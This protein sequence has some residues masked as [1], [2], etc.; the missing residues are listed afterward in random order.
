VAIDDGIGQIEKALGPRMRNTLFVFAS[1]NDWS[2]GAHRWV[3]K[4]VP[5]NESIRVP[6][7]MRWDAHIDPGTTNPRLAVNVDWAETFAAAAG[8]T[9]GGEGEDLLDGQ[10]GRQRFPVESYS[11]GAELGTRQLPTYCG[12]RSRRWLYVKDEYGELELYNEL[13]DPFEMH[14]LAYNPAYHQVL[15]AMHANAVKLCSPPPP[16]FTP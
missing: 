9:Y 12:V 11:P 4:R 13:A 1:D 8:T 3:S 15:A 5:W 6:L 14:N 2:A 10:R 7:I 16:G